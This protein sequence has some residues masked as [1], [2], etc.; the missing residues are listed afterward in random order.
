VLSANKYLYNGK[1]IQDEQLGGVNLDWYDYGARYYDPQLGRWHVI[2]NKAEKYSFITPYAYA[3]NNP[4]IFL[5]PDGNEVWKVTKDNNDGTRNVTVVVNIK[6]NNS[7]GYAA[8]DVKRWSGGIA[9]QIESSFSGYSSQSKTHYNTVVNMDFNGEANSGSY[10]MD[11]TPWVR[12]SGNT[13]T[14]AVGRVDKIGDSKS[15][16]IQ[17]KAPGADNGIYEEQ[18]EGTVGPAGGHEFGHTVGLFHPNSKKNNLKGV[19]GSGNLMYQLSNDKAGPDIVPIQLDEAVKNI[20][21]VN[22]QATNPSEEEKRVID[23]YYNK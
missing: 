21:E 13:R 18:T 6:V 12:N 1:E 14:N 19:D 4:I 17:I 9:K 7:G 11:F 15:N 16:R 23:E 5:D 3:L 22:P 2:D 8:S 20:Q 10:T